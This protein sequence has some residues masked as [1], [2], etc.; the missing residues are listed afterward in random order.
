MVLSNLR[1]TRTLTILDLGIGAQTTEGA[2]HPTKSDITAPENT[3]V[4]AGLPRGSAAVS[5][6]GPA[7]ERQISAVDYAT[8]WAQSRNGEAVASA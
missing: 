1:P 6:V 8:V 5:A 4:S 2:R 3:F 7:S